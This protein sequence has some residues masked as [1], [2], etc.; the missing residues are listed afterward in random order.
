MS[1]RAVCRYFTK[2]TFAVNILL[3]R[4]IHF[5]SDFKFFTNAITAIVSR[6]SVDLKISK[7]LKIFCKTRNTYVK[8]FH[9]KLPY[10][11]I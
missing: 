2:Y 6:Y 11:R 5:Q 7:N 10:L 1:V 9:S 3:L 8:L 4:Y